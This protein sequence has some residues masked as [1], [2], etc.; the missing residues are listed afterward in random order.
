M[1][2]RNIK[3][4]KQKYSRACVTLPYKQFSFSGGFPQ[5]LIFQEIISSA[6]TQLK[7]KEKIE[8]TKLQ[9]CVHMPLFSRSIKVRKASDIL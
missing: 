4:L 8:E 1:N 7:M 9:L 5:F 3:T 6:L 2:L